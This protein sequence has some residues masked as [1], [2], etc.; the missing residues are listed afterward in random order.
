ML[1]GCYNREHDKDPEMFFDVLKELKEDKLPF[2]VSILGEQYKK[3]PGVRSLYYPD[4]FILC[5][6]FLEAC[7]YVLTFIYQ[8]LEF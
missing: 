3:N 6:L 4:N 8:F 5:I 7:N 1:Y 2:K